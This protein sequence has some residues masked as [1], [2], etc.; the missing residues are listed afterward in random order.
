M[1]QLELL[2]CSL[3]SYTEYPITMQ[4]RQLQQIQKKSIYVGRSS[5]HNRGVF[6]NR[7]IR[8]GEIIAEYT[9]EIIRSNLVQLRED[10]YKKK[11][12]DCYFFRLNDLFVIDA[13]NKGN[14]SRFINHSCDPNCCIRLISVESST[15]ILLFSSKEKN[16]GVAFLPCIEKPNIATKY[17][18]AQDRAEISRTILPEIKN[19]GATARLNCTVARLSSISTV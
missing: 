13:T 16:V 4:Y 9:G 6:S 14:S 8:V 15:R 17:N 1:Q 10:R 19:I 7:F 12:I 5:I 11:N 2:H 18:S 3:D